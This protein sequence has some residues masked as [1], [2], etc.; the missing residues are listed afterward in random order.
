MNNDISTVVQ[1]VPQI[2]PDGRRWLERA[3]GRPLRPNERVFVRTEALSDEETKQ[4]AHEEL[5]RIQ[6]EVEAFQKARGITEQEVEAALDEARR[7]VK[8]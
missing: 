3:L 7:A 1:D 4:R 2:D 6:K 8:P 5:I